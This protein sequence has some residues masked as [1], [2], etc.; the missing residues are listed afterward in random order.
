M[1]SWIEL[2]LRLAVAAPFF[3]GFFGK[4]FAGPARLRAEF[5]QFVRLPPVVTGPLSWIVIAWEGATAV[6]LLVPGTLLGA[7]S[8]LVLSLGFVAVTGFLMHRHSGRPCFCFGDLGRLSVGPGLMALDAGLCLG[9]GL[10]VCEGLLSGA[11]RPILYNA[12]AL[13]LAGGLGALTLPVL[14]TRR[15]NAAPTITIPIGA[16]APALRFRAISGDLLDARGER[17][18]RVFLLF[19]SPHCPRC[20]ALL[21]D[22]SLPARVDR[23]L[24]FVVN[25]GAEAAE[26]IA[27]AHGLD[28]GKIIADTAEPR[29]CD[30]FGIPGAPAGVVIADGAVTS[31]HGPAR[32]EDVNRF[33]A[34]R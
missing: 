25:G 4:A 1:T 13:V 29:L 17:D 32:L 9:A 14:L 33:F 16:T 10:L 3:L 22:L 30:A 23:V 27:E 11:T 12:A 19:V 2:I 26:A 31:K 5:A 15:R 8:A 21:A 34:G 6:L 18:P 28:R 24:C 20:E 7:W